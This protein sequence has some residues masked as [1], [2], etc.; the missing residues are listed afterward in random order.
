MW[1]AWKLLHGQ[2]LI[3]PVLRYPETPTI[4]IRASRTPE[5]RTEIC[6]E[7]SLNPAR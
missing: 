1:G 6:S 4:E 7:V 3:W 2:F 5:K